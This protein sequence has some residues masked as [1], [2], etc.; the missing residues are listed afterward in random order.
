MRI[1]RNII[2]FTLIICAAALF[3]AWANHSRPEWVKDVGARKTPSSKKLYLVNDFGFVDVP[4]G[5][6]EQDNST[7]AVKNSND[8]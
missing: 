2:L 3:M 5:S 6:S 1:F 8:V 7:V 4:A